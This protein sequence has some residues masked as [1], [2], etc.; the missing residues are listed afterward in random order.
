MKIVIANE[1]LA[2]RTG[3]ELAARDVA[4]AL[5]KRGHDVVMTALEL[6]PL[7]REMADV[8][9][10]QIAQPDSIGFQPDVIHLNDLGLAQTLS[11]QFPSVPMLLH[12]HKFV[13][14]DFALPSENIRVLCGTTPRINDKIE[15]LTG[16]VPDA[17][18]GNFVDFSRFSARQ[19]KLPSRPSQLLLVGQQKRG[20]RMLT[21]MLMVASRNRV[22]LNLVGPRFL[23]RVDNLPA[24]AAQFDLAIA[25]GRCALECIAAGTGLVVADSNGVGDF[26][27]TAN[28]DR[29]RDGNFSYGSFS[30]ELSYK[31]LL[32]AVQKYDAEEAQAVHEKVRREADIATQIAQIEELYS[33]TIARGN[34]RAS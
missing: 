34:L 23:K 21:L 17:L 9:G 31:R 32:A 13:P 33:L 2:K 18:L 29:F 27:T 26:V 14:E 11:E 12:W 10:L 24:H 20:M 22:R 7:A 6:G 28:Y 30:G 5:Q 1:R 8:D 4:H 25:S 15:R 16:T 3:T 19:T